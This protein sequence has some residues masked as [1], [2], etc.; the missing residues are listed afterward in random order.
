MN[1]EPPISDPA[2]TVFPASWPALGSLALF[3]GV[4]SLLK[5][6]FSLIVI[7]MLPF[8]AIALL[9]ARRMLQH[10]LSHGKARPSLPLFA[11]L[12]VFG[13]A[14]FYVCL[15][16]LADGQTSLVFGLIPVDVRSSLVGYSMM[17]SVAGLLSFI[18]STGAIFASY[19]RAEPFPKMRELYRW[20]TE[21]K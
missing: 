16:L 7:P 18:V 10:L 20:L 8:V 12:Q 4:L 11:R 9:V 13:I 21:F 5:G 15:P 19:I 6:W 1:S 14:A 17:L 2:S 3:L